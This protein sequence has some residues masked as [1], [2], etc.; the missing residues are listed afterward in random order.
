MCASTLKCHWRGP[1]DTETPW[2]CRWSTNPP[3]ECP[4]QTAAVRN[5][6]ASHWN[7]WSKGAAAGPIGCFRLQ[8]ALQLSRE[9]PAAVYL[10]LK[11]PGDAKRR[12]TS[13]SGFS[14]AALSTAHACRAL[15]KS[16]PLWKELQEVSRKKILRLSALGGCWA[17]SGRAAWSEM[18]WQKSSS[19]GVHSIKGGILEFWWLKK[20]T[21]G[22]IRQLTKSPNTQR[23][24]TFILFHVAYLAA[25]LQHSGTTAFYLILG[26]MSVIYK[27]VHAR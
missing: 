20:R 6:A 9:T 22:K 10:P 15:I 14:L 1:L 27:S 18:A 2:S 5:A 25:F 26:I 17:M 8:Q 19:S 23:L 12:W 7:T 21:V 24:P 4:A 3:Q 11:T 13:M 16:L